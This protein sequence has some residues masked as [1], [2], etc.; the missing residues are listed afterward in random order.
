MATLVGPHNLQPVV[1]TVPPTTLK[2]C[3]ARQSPTVRRRAQSGL[4]DARDLRCDATSAGAQKRTRARTVREQTIHGPRTDRATHPG[5]H[6]STGVS[7]GVVMRL[8]GSGRPSRHSRRAG[9]RARRGVRHAE[10]PIPDLVFSTLDPILASCGLGEVSACS[11]RV[12]FHFIAKTLIIVDVRGAAES[13]GRGAAEPSLR[14]TATW[15][16]SLL[17]HVITSRESRDGGG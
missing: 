7:K 17:G 6:R 3:V 2:L 8:R 1:F 10:A 12:A 14:L 15:R 16:P 5:P 13:S 4:G 11:N 9:I